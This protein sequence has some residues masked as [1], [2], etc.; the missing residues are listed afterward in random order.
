MPNQLAIIGSPD[1][2]AQAARK[3][4]QLMPASC[5]AAEKMLLNSIRKSM[6]PTPELSSEEVVPPP[7]QFTT[8]PHL[9]G[10]HLEQPIP[11]RSNNG[12]PKLPLTNLPVIPPPRSTNPFDD[13]LPTTQSLSRSRSNSDASTSSLV[14][15]SSVSSTPQAGVDLVKAKPINLSKTSS[16]TATAVSSSF[17]FEYISPEMAYYDNLITAREAIKK[18]INRCSCWSSIYDRCQVSK[19]MI[20]EENRKI[21]KS[22]EMEDI[23]SVKVHITSEETSSVGIVEGD[24]L[25]FR[26]RATTLTANSRLQHHNQLHSNRSLM[27]TEEDRMVAGV[28]SSE[29]A[30]NDRE[31][32]IPNK[33]FRRSGTVSGDRNRPRRRMG[34]PRLSPVQNHRRLLPI[35]QFEDYTGLFLKVVMEKLVEMMQHPPIV[36]I[37]LTQLISRLTH[38]P[39][40]L[41]RSLLLNHQLVLKPGVPNLFSV[42][43]LK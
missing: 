9:S 25:H 11:V 13:P 21:K 33:G 29:H 7:S 43:H 14:S 27:A 26:S 30:Q 36:N 2:Y 8:S 15:M 18:C 17:K 6:T 34:S 16:V 41:I 12:T 4:L 32:L 19:E 10:N 35:S 40:P 22:L 28:S 42:S 31:S 39:Q 37:L 5:I 23:T 20:L 38:Y 24:N 3:F 1:L